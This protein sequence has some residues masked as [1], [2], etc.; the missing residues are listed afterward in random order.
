MAENG[1]YYLDQLMLRVQTQRSN[2]FITV[3]DDMFTPHERHRIASRLRSADING[4]R[5][6]RFVDHN[7]H[8]TART[9]YAPSA[10]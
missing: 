10:D 1:D 2:R 3:T 8:E 5:D 6:I 7:G 9:R 4:P